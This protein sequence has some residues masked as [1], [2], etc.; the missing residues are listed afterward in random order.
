MEKLKF[1]ETMT[2]EEFKSKMS[3]KLSRIPIQVSASLSMV[4]KLVQ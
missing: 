3:V 2:V 4:L 1:L